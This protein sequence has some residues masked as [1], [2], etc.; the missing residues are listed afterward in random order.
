MTLQTPQ[1]I[2][3]SK[4]WIANCASCAD[5]LGVDFERFTDFDQQSEKLIGFDQEY[6]QLSLGAFDGQF[7]SVD[8]GGGISIHIEYA[9]RA[10]G[11]SMTAPPDCLSIGVVLGQGGFS[12]NGQS[13]AEDAVL[14]AP[15]GSE[16]HFKSPE[17]GSIVAVCI[18]K[19][20]VGRSGIGSG[21]FGLEASLYPTVLQTPDFASRARSDILAT[22]NK[23]SFFADRSMLGQIMA[24]SLLANLAAEMTL[25]SDVQIKSGATRKFETF[26]RVVAL[27]RSLDHSQISLVDLTNRLEVSPRTLQTSFKD[28]VGCGPLE[29]LRILRLCEARSRIVH[30]PASE[31]TIGDIAARSGFYDWSHFS[32]LYKKQFGESP[33]QTRQRQI[34]QGLLS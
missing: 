3:E 15:P 8:F 13:L 17:H 22:L 29:Y 21:L 12:V 9:N 1:N 23:L 4:G 11:Q 28:I 14:F 18:S 2:F 31:D 19:E 6:F 25:R 7:L 34:E 27:S 24:T 10:L 5:Q 16:L 33:S 32:R 30:W 26:Q 20:A